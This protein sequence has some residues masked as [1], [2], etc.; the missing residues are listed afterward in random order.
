M[1]GP[2]SYDINDPHSKSP[3]FRMSKGQRSNDLS[4]SRNTVGPG[5]YDQTHM[6]VGTEGPKFSMG[7]KASAKNRNDSPGPG[8]YDPSLE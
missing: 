5:M 7:V 8:A 1:P 3:G 2:G 6:N 4:A